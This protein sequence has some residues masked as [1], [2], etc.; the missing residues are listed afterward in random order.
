ML[1]S[2]ATEWTLPLTTSYAFLIL[3]RW[4]PS[5]N[6]LYGLE[7]FSSN[8]LLSYCTSLSS[9]LFINQYE[10]TY[11]NILILPFFL[12]IQVFFHKQHSLTH[13]PCILAVHP[14]QGHL[15]QVICLRSGH[16]CFSFPQT[17]DQSIPGCGWY[18]SYFKTFSNGYSEYFGVVLIIC[19]R[20][21]GSFQCK[22]YSMKCASHDHKCYCCL[23]KLVE[24]VYPVV[25]NYEV[26]HSHFTESFHT[27]ISH[28]QK[29]LVQG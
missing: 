20:T 6:T 2:Q 9:A 17:Y 5:I 15:V 18:Y 24:T 16:Q 23:F 26:D 14:P 27:A 11:L 8:T 12:A 22:D 19:S 29:W 7:Q 3:L 13:I 25:L 21:W 10:V 4:I 28:R 1:P